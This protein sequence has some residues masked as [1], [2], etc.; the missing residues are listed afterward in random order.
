MPDN[1]PLWRAENQT[2]RL[3]ELLGIADTKEAPLRRDVR[4][5]GR[6]LGNVIK[7]QEGEQLFETVEALRKLCIAGRGGDYTFAPPLDFFAKLSAREAARLAKAFAMYFEL[8][9]LAETNHRKRRRRAMQLSSDL[10][11]Q[12]G[13]IRGTL[14]RIREAGISFDEMFTVLNLVRVIPVS[15]AHTT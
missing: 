2:G 15:T 8:T 3:K 12:P 13:T 11:R 1:E 14:L 5:L 7:D 10:A 9:N 4:S 6:L